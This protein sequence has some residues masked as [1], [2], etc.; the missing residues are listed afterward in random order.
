M[1]QVPYAM[2]LLLAELHRVC[3]YTV[4][5]HIYYSKVTQ[6]YAM[7]FVGSISSFFVVTG[8]LLA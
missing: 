1:N 4:P 3:I 7:C 6:T 8:V 5:K 2:D